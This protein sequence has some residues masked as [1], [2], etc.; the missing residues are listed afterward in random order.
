LHV[1]ICPVL[2]EYITAMLGLATAGSGDPKP[3]VQACEP[4][5]TY[6]VIVISRVQISK[7]PLGSQAQG[8]RSFTSLHVREILS[9]NLYTLVHA[10]WF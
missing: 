9:P 5:F 8:N 10:R 1:K 7:A 2:L 4:R 3:T 6:F